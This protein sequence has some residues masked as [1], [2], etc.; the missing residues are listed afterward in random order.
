MTTRLPSR[1][2]RVTP[3][4]VIIDEPDPDFDLRQI[5]A[6]SVRDTMRDRCKQL[7]D[8]LH[9]EFSATD[10]A[11]VSH[12]CVGSTCF[13]VLWHARMFATLRHVDRAMDQLKQ[14]VVDLSVMDVRKINERYLTIS[15]LVEQFAERRAAGEVV[16]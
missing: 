11:I 2:S 8:D 1:P 3:L 12:G 7:Y 6:K 13:H 16:W 9:A 5:A 4:N 10:D 14:E 15:A